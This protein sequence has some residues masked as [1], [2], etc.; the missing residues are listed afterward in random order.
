MATG[1][2]KRSALLVNGAVANAASDKCVQSACTLLPLRAL[3][4]SS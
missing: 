1:A 4:L 3:Q 2:L